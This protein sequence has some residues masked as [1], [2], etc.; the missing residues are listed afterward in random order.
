MSSFLEMVRSNIV[1]QAILSIL[2][3]LFLA[4]WP[5]STTLTVVY[6]LALVL[7]VTGATSLIAYF[8]HKGTSKGSSGVL[9]TGIFFLLVALFMVIFPEAIAGL[10]SLV[11][12]LLLTLSGLVNVVRS[13]E[14]RGYSGNAWI[15]MLV[16]SLV[17]A[18]GGV[19]IVVNPFDTTV[20][21]VLVLGVLLM[22]KGVVDLVIEV[23][24]RRS[25]KK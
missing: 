17:V 8:R 11:L 25:S 3:G 21:F 4:I 10:F 2:L 5:E 19:V 9:A 18:I 23:T 16:V 14:L 1:V 6:L 20:M 7:A 22:I 13:I 24:L 15:F 12:G